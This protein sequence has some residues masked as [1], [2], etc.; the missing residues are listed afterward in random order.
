MRNDFLPVSPPCISDEE[1]AEGVDTCGGL[2][3]PGPKRKRFEHEFAA[4][5][6]AP[7][8]G[9][10]LLYCRLHPRAHHMGMARPMLS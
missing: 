5:V 8:P 6:N 3:H 7:A 1:I 10:K 9:V 2:D 4:A